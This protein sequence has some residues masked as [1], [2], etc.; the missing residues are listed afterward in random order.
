MENLYYSLDNKTKNFS[1]CLWLLSIISWLLLIFTSFYS[2]INIFQENS[3]IVFTI[4]KYPLFKWISKGIS[5]TG[6]TIYPL[7]MH[8]I[9]FYIIIII[10]SFFAIFSFPIYLI[11][12]LYKRKISIYDN[13]FQSIHKFNFIPLL[14]ISILFI[15]G[16]SYMYN[17]SRW[18]RR[19][20]L[21]FFFNI[22]GLISIIFVYYN[23]KLTTISSI[24]YIYII[25]K[26]VYSCIIALEWYYFCYIITNIFVLY[27]SDEYY[28][29]LIKTFGIL[30]PLLFGSGAIIFSFIFK[31]IMIAFLSLIV[32][33]GC[34]TYFF[35]ISKIYR[36]QYNEVMDGV[37][38]IIM[39]ILLIT[40]IIYIFTKYRKDI[41]L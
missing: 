4:V 7:H 40:E 32:N 9:F 38:N 28:F 29:S 21:G 24:K 33:I 12:I 36:K 18:E 23:T 20:I 10:I 25:K 6:G 16:E 14:C 19:N 11:V 8:P 35:S 37:I 34:I 31:D 39:S 13:F 2:F 30:L 3:G 17:V 26:G 5:Y 15:I 1:N 22:I 27:L 41:L